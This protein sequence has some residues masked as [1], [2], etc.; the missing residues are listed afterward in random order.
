LT[1]A[2]LESA[3]AS[4]MASVTAQDIARGGRTTLET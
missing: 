3:S 4:D 1:A 2:L